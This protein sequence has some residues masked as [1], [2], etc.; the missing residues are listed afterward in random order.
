M[1]PPPKYLITR[2]LVKR[3]FDNYLPKEPLHSFSDGQKLFECW[4]IHGLDSAKC[5]EQE[6][7][8]DHAMEESE[9]YRRKINSMNFKSAILGTLKKPVYQKETKGRYRFDSNMKNRDIFDG[10][11]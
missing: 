3:F 10:V 2:K 7:L 4:Q 1:A 6:L 11:S 9:N 8:F 5:K